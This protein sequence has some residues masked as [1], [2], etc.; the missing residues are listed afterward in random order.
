MTNE[1]KITFSNIKESLIAVTEEL[2]KNR[3]YYND[4]DSPLGDSDHGDS[5]CGS[6]KTIK[7]ILLECS[8]ENDDIGVLLKNV[9]KTILLSGGGA[10]G[11]LFG[12]AFIDAGKAVSGKSIIF[13]HDFVQMWIAFLGA[14][15]KRGEKV[16]EKTMYDTIRPAIDTLELAYSE[17]KTLTEACELV[18]KAAKIGMQSTKDMIA[19]RGRSSRLGERTIGHIDPG[20]ASMY[21]LVSTFFNTIKRLIKSTEN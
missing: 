4:L 1:N 9:G 5:V 18:V 13:Y 14:I 20:S 7:G 2:E 17:G 19:L 21:T 11:P 12:S 15:G 8:I 3:Q 10:M 6:F 16:G